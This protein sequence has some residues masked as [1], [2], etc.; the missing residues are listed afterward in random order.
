MDGHRVVTSAR[1]ALLILFTLC[2]AATSAQADSWKPAAGLGLGHVDHS[3]TLLPNGT[4]IITG[5]DE[6]GASDYDRTR[7]IYDPVTNSWHTTTGMSSTPRIF[8]TATVLNNG[9]L[10]VAGG[11]DGYEKWNVDRIRADLNYEGNGPGAYLLV[12][13]CHHTAT[14]L[15]D[16][17]VLVVGGAIAVPNKSCSA[18]PL[19][20]AELFDPVSSSWSLAAPMAVAR[21][22]HT[23]TLLANGKVLVVGGGTTGNVVVPSSELYDPAT[24]S[25]A[26]VATP[27]SP[28]AAHTATLLASGNVLAAGGINDVAYLASAEIYNPISNAWTATPA[29]STSRAQH[30]AL[31][32]P[33]SK[34]MIAGGDNSDF[35]FA[36]TEIYDPATNTWVDGPDMA[37]YRVFHG[38]TLLPDGR[39]LMVGGYDGSYLPGVEIYDATDGA[40]AAT[41]SMA[42]PRR[43]HISTLL[44]S[45]EVLVAGGAN[46]A[47]VAQATAEIYDPTLAS[48]RAAAPMLTAR[49]HFAASLLTTGQVLVTGG[50]AFAAPTAELYDP[51]ADAWTTTPM[52]TPRSNNTS[53][54]LQDGRVLV[55]GGFSSSVE[56]FDP[57]TRRWTAAA[58][59]ATARGQHSATLLADG[60]VLV[61]AGFNA[62]DQAL[63]SA[64]IYDPAT[65]TWSGA[66]TLTGT[67]YA[68]DA[69]LL[70]DGK[71]LVGSCLGTSEENLYNPATNSWSAVI[72]TVA[73]NQKAVV[74]SNGNAAFLGANTTAVFHPG[75]DTWSYATGHP[76]KARTGA[77]ATLL[78]NGK[79]LVTG[80]FAL[81]LELSN[82]DLF[83]AGLAPDPSRRPIINTI[84]DSVLPNNSNPLVLTGTGFRPPQEANG[85]NN[86]GSASNFALVR[87]MSLGNEQLRWLSKPVDWTLNSDNY[88]AFTA[89]DMDGF[90][91]GYF[92]VT[93]FVN[94]VPSVSRLVLRATDALFG[95]GFE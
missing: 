6:V 72:G 37:D 67:C 68:H 43:F 35:Y 19:S 38:A 15:P 54:V 36:S 60:R 10:L 25:W 1:P 12:K 94:G 46:S 56:L 48:W 29:L 59:M 80:G 90:P 24:N 42:V 51:D 53:T 83:D 74:L 11:Y 76:A 62:T 17:R 81:G 79:V 4:V 58:P 70:A 73:T 87:I 64:E 22:L 39:V 44:S 5:G 88:L 8:Q 61:A 20:S 7:R 18:S 78:A 92:L 84:T 28:R 32:L 14:L 2:L 45:G 34:V 63:N 89:D 55:A 66:G 31:L 93:V 21:Y 16:G 23:A 50:Q 86:M 47:G 57:A 91:A 13:R 41:A 65:N 75:L 71:V 33:S 82:A 77:E 26:T 52:L 49:Q 95:N 9:D 69:A 85:G 30:S 40:W 3:A 27:I